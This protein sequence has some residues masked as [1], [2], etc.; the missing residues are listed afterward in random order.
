MEAYFPNKL[1]ELR[2]TAGYTQKEVAVFLSLSHTEN[3]LRWEK[4]YVLP[5]LIYLYQLSLL[6]KVPVHELYFDIWDYFKEEM[7]LKLQ[8][9]EKNIFINQLSSLEAKNK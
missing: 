9:H 4:G 7:N 3:I 8:Q 6:Y 1:K 2:K 5:G